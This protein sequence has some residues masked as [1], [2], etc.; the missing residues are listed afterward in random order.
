MDYKAFLRIF[1]KYEIQLNNEQNAK[2]GSRNETFISDEVIRKK[3]T[4]F[5]R[6]KDA[7][8]VSGGRIG[9]KDLFK[10]AD[11]NQSYK[12]DKE[13][14]AQMLRGLRMD[15][16]SAVDV[17][18]LFESVDFDGSGQISLIEFKADFEAVVSTDVETLI[19]D[20]KSKMSELQNTVNPNNMDERSLMDL[21]NKPETR[22]I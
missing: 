3:K 2:R 15:D 1:A 20:N 10:R 17:Q 7:L 21:L 9:L 16:V 8:D 13:E 4:I 22:E 5:N 18:Q 12:I 19:R 11:E 6:I 14:F